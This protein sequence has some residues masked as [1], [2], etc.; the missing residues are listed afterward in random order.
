MCLGQSINSLLTA[1]SSCQFSFDWASQT[2]Q[3]LKMR[4]GRGMQLLGSVQFLVATGGQSCDWTE[5]SRLLSCCRLCGPFHP[6]PQFWWWSCSC[7][8]DC[9]NG[10]RIN[11][12]DFS[13]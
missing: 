7:A 6:R 3:Y 11:F 13:Y 1:S 9:Q 8:G 4:F 5:C 10:S 12:N 2:N